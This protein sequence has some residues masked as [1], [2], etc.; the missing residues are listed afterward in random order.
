M[1]AIPT[2]RDLEFDGPATREQ[3]DP[4]PAITSLLPA[5]PAV[6][7]RSPTASEDPFDHHPLLALRK[8][9]EG[10]GWTL[11]AADDP[12]WAPH[13][14]Y[15]DRES[16]LA[17]V[18]R[19]QT[20]YA[21]LSVAQRARKAATRE[22]ARAISRGEKPA[23]TINDGSANWWWSPAEGKTHARALLA[24]RAAGKVNSWAKRNA[25]RET[26]AQEA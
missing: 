2:T 11:P 18:T 16:Y 5:K 8:H 22:A 20:V 10:E 12:A 13:L 24:L 17:W 9:V 7:R 1:S 19:W 21:A 14:T 3:L 25:A 6:L 4:I 15:T 26:Q 23:P